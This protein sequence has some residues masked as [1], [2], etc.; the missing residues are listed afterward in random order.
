VSVVLDSVLDYQFS[1][2][3]SATH[4]VPS[5]NNSHLW[6]S[7]YRRFTDHTENKAPILAS[8]NV[9]TDTLPSNG[10]SIVV[11][12]LRGKVFTESLPSNDHI[13]LLFIHF[14]TDSP[15]LTKFGMV[16]EISL[17][18]FQALENSNLFSLCISQKLLETPKILFLLIAQEPFVLVWA[19]SSFVFDTAQKTIKRREDLAYPMCYVSGIVFG[20]TNFME[21]SPPW[22]AANFASYLRTSQHFMETERSLPCSQE[23]STG[24]YPQP[25][26]PSLYQLILSKIHLNIIHP[27]IV[28][29][30]HFINLKW[31]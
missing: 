4:G 1:K 24:P 29:E 28:F 6:L 7:L 26:L 15:I 27:L 19:F 10:H 21:L 14:Q 25:D 18:R 13:R 16:V 17:E 3:I 12:R 8:W 9:F 23:P 11:M 20:L 22:E 31:S 2:L 5:T 30:L